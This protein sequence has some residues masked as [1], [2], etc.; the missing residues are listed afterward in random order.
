MR[1]ERLGIVFD[2]PQDAA[3][4]LSLSPF[5][6]LRALLKPLIKL[7]PVASD[8]KGGSIFFPHILL[9]SHFLVSTVIHAPTGS[10]LVAG[11]SAVYDFLMLLAVAVLSHAP[12]ACVLASNVKSSLFVLGTDLL[13]SGD[14][15]VPSSTASGSQKVVTPHR[16]CL[17]RK[18]PSKTR[19]IELGEERPRI[20]GALRLFR[21]RQCLFRRRPWRFRRF[22]RRS[23]FGLG[24]QR[25]FWRDGGERIV[26]AR[27]AH[28]RLHLLRVRIRERRQR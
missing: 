3:S 9:P 20:H 18:T 10:T 24:V 5:P 28:V 2:A 21:L 17:D 16:R 7:I 27:H 22:R 23:R 26:D 12:A 19:P 15:P 4:P 8:P 25:R 11:F 13:L 1:A 6:P 14:S